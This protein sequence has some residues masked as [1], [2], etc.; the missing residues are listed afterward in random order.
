MWPKSDQSG[1]QF[2]KIKIAGRV[3]SV[4]LKIINQLWHWGD[5]INSPQLKVLISKKRLHKI[6]HGII[7]I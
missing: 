7:N 5:D 1:R 3:K 6:T 2:G 4:L